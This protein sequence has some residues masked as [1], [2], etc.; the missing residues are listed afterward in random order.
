[1]GLQLVLTCF[2]FLTGAW[3]SDEIMVKKVRVLLPFLAASNISVP[4]LKKKKK[5]D[6]FISER[7]PVIVLLLL[8]FFPQINI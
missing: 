6:G 1:M 4:S 5:L 7:S 3:G 8:L 2:T